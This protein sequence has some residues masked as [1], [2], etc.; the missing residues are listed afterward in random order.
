[1]NININES[2]YII[3]ALILGGLILTFGHNVVNNKKTAVPTASVTAGQELK[4]ISIG[5]KNASVVVTEYT[6]FLCSHCVN[7]ALNVMPSIEEKYIKTSQVKWNFVITGPTE[8]SQASF[9]A[10][11]QGKYIEYHDYLFN[12]QSELTKVDDLYTL[13]AQAGLNTNELKQCL[14]SGKYKDI[15]D[16]LVKESNDKGVDGTPTFFIG[17]S[18]E[19]DKTEKIVGEQTFE[20]FE[21]VLVKYLR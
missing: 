18:N 17:K 21:K 13:A 15:A 9:C 6:S 1:M 8:I 11:E 12:H 14:E 2:K 7:F 20:E 3:A 5:D 16:N 19:P 10:D 4:K